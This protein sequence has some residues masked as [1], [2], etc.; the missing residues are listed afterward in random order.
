MDCGGFLSSDERAHLEA[1]VRRPTERHGIARRAN[2]MLLLDDG[3]RCEEVARVLYLD[4]DTIRGWRD[5]YRREGARALAGLRLEGRAA[6]ARCRRRR[7]SSWRRSTR[8][9]SRPPPR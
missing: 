3:L 5:R 1:L 4:D 9:S 7:R 8:S 6:P 2:A